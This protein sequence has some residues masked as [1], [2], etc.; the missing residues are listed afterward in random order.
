M[1]VLETA[2][3]MIRKDLPDLVY[4][5]EFT[6]WKAVLT[7]SKKC[8]SLGQPILIGTASVEKS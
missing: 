3:P 4:Q 8:F 7:Q 5:S 2:K 6:K 1:R